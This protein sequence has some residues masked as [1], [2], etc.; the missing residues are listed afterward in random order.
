MAENIKKIKTGPNFDD[1][2]HILTNR[3][4]GKARTDS[5]FIRSKTILK[6]AEALNTI[7]GADVKIAIYPTCKGG[8]ER[9]WCSPGFQE[10]PEPQIANPTAANLAPAEA[11]LVPAAPPVAV[12]SPR[13]RM[14][15]SAGARASASASRPTATRIRRCQEVD[16]CNIC[17]ITF[18][19]A[20]EQEMKLCTLW[21]Q[22]SKSCGYWIHAACGGIYYPD[23]DSGEKALSKWSKDHYYCPRHQPK[24]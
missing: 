24:N 6:G 15:A 18:D 10:R 12:E 11:A 2:G 3:R 9:I 5:Y 20:A 16:T 7:T 17:H 22:C 19:T 23:T 1:A 14:S 21:V 4:Q 8:K 13:K